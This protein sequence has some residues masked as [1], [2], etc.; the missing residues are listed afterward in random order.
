MKN[1]LQFI[2]V[3]LL[4]SA[5]TSCV[6]AKKINNKIAI[7]KEY[8]GWF[9]GTSNGIFFVINRKGPFKKN[10]AFILGTF[11]PFCQGQKEAYASFFNSECEKRNDDKKG[12]FI[13][14]RNDSTSI[15]QNVSIYKAKAFY[16]DFD[17]TYINYAIRKGQRV[18][19]KIK[20]SDGI[21]S[22][23]A[24][25]VDGFVDLRN[26]VLFSNCNKDS[27]KYFDCPSKKIQ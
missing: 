11:R 22:I 9:I 25:W 10:I 23:K 13:I 18:V 7:D 1:I 20:A 12:F 17:T 26:L 8:N 21:S 27:L 2:V 24:I 14:G 16:E 19:Y 4:A 5:Y 6:N 3:L 15:G